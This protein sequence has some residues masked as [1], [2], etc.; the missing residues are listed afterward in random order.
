MKYFGF[1]LADSMFVGECVIV[2]RN[3]TVDEVKLAVQEGVEPCL[4]PSHQAT[5]N[6]MRSRYGIDVAI[7]DAPPPGVSGSR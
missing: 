3:L 7:P 5:I 2:R 1:A 6:A 4:N